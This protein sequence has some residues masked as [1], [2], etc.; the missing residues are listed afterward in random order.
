MES[1]KSP[2]LLPIRTGMERVP[3]TWVFLINIPWAGLLYQEFISNTAMTFT[4]RRFIEDPRLIA[5][6][7]SVNVAFNFLVAAVGNY[8]SDRIWTRWGRRRPFLIAGGIGASVM[9]FILPLLPNLPTLIVGIIIF[10][11]F[12]DLAIPLEPLVMEVVPSRQ[13]GRGQSM[14]MILQGLTVFYFYNLMFARFDSVH[15][16]PGWLRALGLSTLNGEI[17]TYWSGGVL[18]LVIV[19][20]YALLVRETPVAPVEGRLF[21][22]AGFFRDVFGDRRAW[23]IYVIYAAPTFIH[24]VWGQFQ[25]LLMTEQFGYAKSVVAVTALPGTLLNLVLFVPVLGWL[26]DRKPTISGWGSGAV[27]AV[28]IAGTVWFVPRL[29]GGLSEPPAFWRMLVL[30]LSVAVAVLAAIAFLQVP[31]RRLLPGANERVSLFAT[32]LSGVAV[33]ALVQWIVVKLHAPGAP[34]LGLLFALAQVTGGLTTCGWVVMGPMLFDYI[35]KDRFGTVSA[36]MGFVSSVLRFLIMNLAG[37]WVVGMSGWF[38]IAAGRDYA[39]CFL[40]QALMGVPSILC[41]WYFAR[42]VREGRIRGVE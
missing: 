1:P 19:L 21:T 32:G 36:G 27:R 40:L 39:S 14:R 42:G 10:Q 3:W 30:G 26:A 41:V 35:P 2:P 4:L 24:A 38:P 6:V 31:L 7:G 8:L 23:I 13:R 33:F 29:G 17:L 16:V 28:G 34:S 11:F 18:A 25:P 37:F 15:E 22:P 12:V 5:L 20:I 9:L